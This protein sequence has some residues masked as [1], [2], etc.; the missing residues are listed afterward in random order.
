MLPGLLRVR[1]CGDQAVPILSPAAARAPSVAAQSGGRL[2]DAASCTGLTLAAVIF[3]TARRKRHSPFGCVQHPRTQPRRAQPQ[4][5]PESLRWALELA[6]RSEN[7][8]E[9]AQLRKAIPAAEA[10]QPVAALD[11]LVHERVQRA[12]DHALDGGVPTMSRLA[13][14]RRL[15]VLATPPAATE[16]AEDAL[17]QVLR[18]C[19]DEGVVELAEAAL[20]AAWLPS[21]DDAVDATMREGLRL[22]GAGELAE[23]ADAFSK[24]VAAAP[25]YAEGWNKRATALFLAEKFD[26]SI[27]VCGRVLELKPRHFGC[28]SGL[29]I[30]HLRKGDELT[31]VRWLRKALDVNPR[32]SD[33]Q[34]IVADLE[35]RFASAILRPRI[36][37]VLD[38]M[39]AGRPAGASAARPAGALTRV[40]AEWDAYRMQDIEKCTY[41]FRV[42]VK[43]LQGH[44]VSGVARYYALQQGGS[45][46]PLSRMTQGP[47]SFTLG[48][49]QCFQY[50]FML[51][52]AKELS[53]A[54]GGLLLRCQEDLFEV[55][56]GRLLLQD[57]P[58]AREFDLAKLN[59]GYTF[60]GRL[61]IHIED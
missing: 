24:A 18:E 10:A 21:G 56:L 40:Q 39:K 51:T 20:W 44:P 60:M 41:Y 32:S 3:T 1:S 29:G 28:L 57:A 48:P 6:V 58:A 11:S 31:A 54:Q 43:C 13:A 53:A 34:R 30:C 42:R 35:M 47:A 8:E 22:M 16:E 7:Y 49:G 52:F 12:L 25:T 59:E 61:D 37:D 55:G 45:V 36:Q 50:S 46:L 15:Q 2:A 19:D 33:M 5:D 17:Y 14:V 23:A 26:E 9:A 4:T 27:E 38:E